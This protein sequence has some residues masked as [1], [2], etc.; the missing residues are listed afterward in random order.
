[1]PTFKLFGGTIH[2]ALVHAATAY[3]RRRENKPGYNIYAL[4]QY[5]GRIEEVEADIAAGA[6]VRAALIAAF[7]DRLLDALLTAV[8]ESKHTRDEKSGGYMYVPSVRKV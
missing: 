4:S 5:L 2:S 3:D 8:G 7:S 1:M 6:T